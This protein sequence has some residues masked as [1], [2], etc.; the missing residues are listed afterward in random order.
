MSPPIR[1]ILIDDH[2]HIHDAVA[3]ALTQADDIHLAAQGSTGDEAVILCRQHQPDIVL[4]DVVMP[5]MDGVT[6]TK[7]LKSEFPNVK[8]LVLSS[9][10]DDDTVHAMMREGASGYTLKHSLAANL[11]NAIRATHMGSVVIDSE[12]SQG[13]LQPPSPPAAGNSF[14]LT[15]RELEVLRLMAHGLTNNEIAVKLFISRS[16]VKFHITNIEE[17]MGV[18]TRAEAIVLAAKNNLV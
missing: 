9:F 16:T 8:I 5:G 1:V 13:L 3:L 17:K 11:V 4:M 6:A 15:E 18:T 12:V 10:Q 2:K 7:R 14:D